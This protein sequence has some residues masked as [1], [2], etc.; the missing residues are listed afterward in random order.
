MLPRGV[1]VGAGALRTQPREF[2]APWIPRVTA[3]EACDLGNREDRHGSDDTQVCVPRQVEIL[4]DN[5]GWF[6]YSL[7]MTETERRDIE[8]AKAHRTA[9]AA[10]TKAISRRARAAREA[11]DSATAERLFTEVRTRQAGI[12]VEA[13]EAVRQARIN[14]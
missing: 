8:M 11:G 9:V 13:H 4:V 14:S 5:Y 10:E 6:T 12:E 3:P 7:F 2:W 1:P